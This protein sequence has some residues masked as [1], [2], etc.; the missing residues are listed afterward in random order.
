MIRSFRLPEPGSPEITLEITPWWNL[1]VTASGA[2]IPRKG[3]SLLGQRHV[4]TMADGS[5]RTFVVKDVPFGIRVELPTGVSLVLE[6]TPPLWIVALSLVPFIVG[7]LGG[8]VGV[9]LAVLGISLSL[10]ILRRSWS[11]AEQAVAIVLVDAVSIG[12][13]IAISTTL[14]RILFPP[15]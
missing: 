14:S 15:R 8:V 9:L 12:A 4:V 3:W 11:R 13:I 1:K 5:T 2:K 10:A 6:P 7:A